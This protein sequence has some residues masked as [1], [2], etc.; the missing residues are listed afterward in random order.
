MEKIAI[1]SLSTN[2]P[3]LLSAVYS[4]GALVITSVKKLP[5]TAIEQRIKTPSAIKKLCKENYKVLVD[6]LTPTISKGTGASQITLKSRHMDNRP[7]IIVGMERY[8]E[9]KHQGLISL[10]AEN[11]AWFEIPPSIVDVEYN[12]NGDPVYRINWPE[13][14]P[15][16]VAMILCCYATVYHN[17]ASGDYIRQ[18]TGADDADRVPGLLAPFVNIISHESRAAATVQPKTLAGSRRSENEVVL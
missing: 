5:R 3:L 13:I 15:E 11:K 8:Q 1:F 9:L 7:A 2:K 10:P 18:L 17:V 12:G 16:H 4:D 6:E 14:R